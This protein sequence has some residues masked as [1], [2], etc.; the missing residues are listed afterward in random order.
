V[1][2]DARF[3]QQIAKVLGRRVTPLPGGAAQEGQGTR[4]N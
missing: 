2:G 4:G 3:K 1:I